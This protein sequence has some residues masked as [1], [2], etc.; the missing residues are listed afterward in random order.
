MGPDPVEVSAVNI[1]SVCIYSSAVVRG[2]FM[3]VVVVI[4]VI[5]V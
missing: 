5:I 1:L 2:H 4:S 3:A